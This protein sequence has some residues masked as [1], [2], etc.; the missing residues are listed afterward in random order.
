MLVKTVDYTGIDLRLNKLLNVP[1]FNRLPPPLATKKM[2]GL[3]YLN[4]L[5]LPLNINRGG[6]KEDVR[7]SI[8]QAIA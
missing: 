3:F 7:Q 2:L 5:W 8:L 4:M 6:R 1:I